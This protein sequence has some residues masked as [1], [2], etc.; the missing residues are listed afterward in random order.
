MSK[1]TK[2]TKPTVSKG[3]LSVPLVPGQKTSVTQSVG[4]PSHAARMTP[5]TDHKRVLRDVQMAG[6]PAHLQKPSAASEGA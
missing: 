4:N 5:L 3:K 1:T 6:I 2:I